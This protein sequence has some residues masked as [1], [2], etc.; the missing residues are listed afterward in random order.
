MF[1]KPR[2]D[3]GISTSV[4]D[5]A[6]N[7]GS[8]TRKG[9]LG[10]IEEWAERDGNGGFVKKFVDYGN[11]GRERYHG[12]VT[13]SREDVEDM[14]F[15]LQELLEGD[16]ETTHVKFFPTLKE[17]KEQKEKKTEAVPADEE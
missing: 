3:G 13:L 15:R 17:Q 14:I 16:V 4:D 6:K 7:V 8:A 5:L 9:S 11:Y 10:R 12:E 1:T 2:A